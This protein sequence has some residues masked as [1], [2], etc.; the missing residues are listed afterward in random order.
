MRIDRSTS[1]RNDLPVSTHHQTLTAFNPQPKRRPFMKSIKQ[2]IAAAT[3]TVIGLSAFAQEA[4][5]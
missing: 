1:Y 4:T 5:P 2:L 3:L